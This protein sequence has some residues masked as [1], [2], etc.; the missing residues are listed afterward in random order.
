MWLVQ[1]RNWIV[2][3]LYLKLYFR[4]YCICLTAHGLSLAVVPG[5]LI[6]VTSLVAERGL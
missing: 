1:L 3:F 2:D 5:L 4:L 6:V